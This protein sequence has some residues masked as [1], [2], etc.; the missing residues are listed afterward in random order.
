M[1]K[2]TVT[3]SETVV[4][5]EQARAQFKTAKALVDELNAKHKAE[6]KVARAEKEA[7]SAKRAEVKVVRDAEKAT[8]Q[9]ERV[10]KLEAALEKARQAAQ[11]GRGVGKVV[12]DSKKNGSVT[13]IKP[14]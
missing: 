9:A 8:K 10:K 3:K 12:R 11:V 7:N 13:V 14:E 6:L 4:Q 5:L 2:Q 1:T